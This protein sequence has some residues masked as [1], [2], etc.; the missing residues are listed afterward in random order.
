M[1]AILDSSETS[2]QVRLANRSLYDA[3]RTLV[4]VKDADAIHKDCIGN[5]ALSAKEYNSDRGVD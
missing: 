4:S 3:S 2:E 1:A 5:A